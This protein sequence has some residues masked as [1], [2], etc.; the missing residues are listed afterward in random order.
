MRRRVVGLLAAATGV[1]ALSLAF[2]PASGA[3]PPIDAAFA[4]VGRVI[5]SGGSSCFGSFTKRT[6]AVGTTALGTLSYVTT[7]CAQVS[8]TLTAL[9]GAL[10]GSGA[11]PGELN[12]LLG[13]GGFAYTGAVTAASGSY[14]GLAGHS[15]TLTE[16]FGAIPVGPNPFVFINEEPVFGTLVVN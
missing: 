13:G 4:G 12:G 16:N 5:Q 1:M 10:T 11:S 6:V 3:S 8:F 14:G 9:R 15:F 2:Q 7:P